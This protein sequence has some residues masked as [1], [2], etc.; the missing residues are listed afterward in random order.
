MLPR[1]VNLRERG[2]RA[3]LFSED[4]DDLGFCHLPWPLSS[5]D[6]AAPEGAIYRVIAYAYRP[7]G[8]IDA[9]V[10]VQPV[11]LALGG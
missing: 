5:A 1:V 9:I 6:L 2:V 8:A 11:Q 3:H 4:G 10:V 7:D